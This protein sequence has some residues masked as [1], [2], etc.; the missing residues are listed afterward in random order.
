MQ[1]AESVADTASVTRHACKTQPHGDPTVQNME[2][3]WNWRPVKMVHRQR[4]R[5]KPPLIFVGAVLFYTHVDCVF[6]YE[7]VQVIGQ[8]VEWHMAGGGLFKACL[9]PTRAAETLQYTLAK[10]KNKQN[11]RDMQ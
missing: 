4:V 1:I 11:D 2:D 3:V 9:A 8:A 5:T 7:A 6:Q 10:E